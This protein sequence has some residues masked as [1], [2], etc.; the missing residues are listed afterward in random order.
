LYPY[1]P[2]MPGRQNF[3]DTEEA[4]R[5]HQASWNVLIHFG[6]LVYHHYYLT[7]LGLSNHPQDYDANNVYCQ[8]KH[9]PEFVTFVTTTIGRWMERAYR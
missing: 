9:G 7:R 8:L 5:F 1:D 6:S 3:E 4:Y 2:D